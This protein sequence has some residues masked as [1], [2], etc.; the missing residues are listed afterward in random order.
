MIMGLAIAFGVVAFIAGLMFRSWRMILITLVV[1]IIPLLMVAG[2]MGISGITLKLTTS[3][4]FTVAFG[5]AVDDTIHFISKLQ[6]ELAKGKS[7]LYAIKRTYFSTGKAIV[8]TTLILISG[9]LTL[10]LS[11]FGGTFY[12]G[13]FV[14][15]TLLFALITDLT[16][17]PVLILLFYRRD[18]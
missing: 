11:S 4:I 7:P 1:N 9:F 16:L 14:G 3:V 8:I 6:M 18:H 15:L 13:L 12:I 10:L 2:I 5:I 17:L